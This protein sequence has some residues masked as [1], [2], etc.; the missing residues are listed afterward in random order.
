M[1]V[2]SVI[3]LIGSIISGGGLGA[4][5]GFASKV[6]EHKHEVALEALKLKQYEVKTAYEIKMAETSNATLT[7]QSTIQ[8]AIQNNLNTV[9]PSPVVSPSIP[10]Q[11][12]EVGDQ[13]PYD[14]NKDANYN[15]A[16][17]EV[18]KANYETDKATYATGDAA[19]NSKLLI[20]VDFCRGITR[21]VLTWALDL[22]VLIFAIYLIVILKDNI[23]NISTK[24]GIDLLVDTV[25]SLTFLA[26]TATVYWYASRS[27]R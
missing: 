16:S 26:S 11:S 24:E 14:P 9:I 2:T 4:I 27:V 17:L 1:E 10:E 7:I 20:F 25:H 8:S 15:L 12:K 22:S 18:L 6:L 19:K 5:G 3:G 21:P 13:I 23:V